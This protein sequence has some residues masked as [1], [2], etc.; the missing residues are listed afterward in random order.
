MQTKPKYLALAA[1]VAGAIVLAGCNKKE[2]AAP[3]SSGAAPAASTP[4]APA[5]PA[6]ATPAAPAASS[7]STASIPPECEAYMQKVDACVGKLGQ[8]NPAVGAVKQQL[9]AARAQWSTIGD[10]SQLAAQ[11][12]QSND[13]FSQSASQMGC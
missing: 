5:A 6:P 4:A 13:L 10:K 1:I 12:K 11:C 8:S 2:E 9:D 3:A 7:G